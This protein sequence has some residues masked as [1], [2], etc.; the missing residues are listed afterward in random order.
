MSDHNQ[1][2]EPI[3]FEPASAPAA[4]NGQKPGPST[5]TRVAPANSRWQLPALG[6][7]LLVA[8]LVFFW[9]PSQ[10]DTTKVELETPTP[11]V[12]PVKPAAEQ[13]SPWSDAPWD[14][15]SP[16]WKSP[17]CGPKIWKPRIVTS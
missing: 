6:G 1:K 14:D 4:E 15:T 16:T 10:V 17:S 9:L 2:V 11:T 3:R 12:S 5:A 13:A 7:L 8:L